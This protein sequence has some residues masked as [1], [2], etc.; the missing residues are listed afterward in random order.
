MCFFTDRNLDIRQS[1]QRRLVRPF[2]TALLRCGKAARIVA[3]TRNTLKD[4]ENFQK[5]GNCKICSGVISEQSIKS[6]LST[7]RTRRPAS[8]RLLCA[9][10][11]AR[12]KNKKYSSHG[13]ITGAITGVIVGA[14]TGVIAGLIDGTVA[15]EEPP[16]PPV[17][18]L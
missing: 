5:I 13:V 16:L 2:S 1:L 10:R 18:N 14:I 17:K 12:N 8:L 3:D 15:V 11:E 9:K 4:I 7:Q 6:G